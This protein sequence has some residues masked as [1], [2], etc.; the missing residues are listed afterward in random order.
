[1]QRNNS[2]KRL[3]RKA[4]RTRCVLEFLAGGIWA[5]FMILPLVLPVPEVNA[6]ESVP[7]APLMTCAVEAEMENEPVLYDVPLDDELQLFIIQE[8]EEHHIEPEI[9]LAMIE[10]ESQFTADIVGDNGN[11]FGYLQIQPRWHYQRMLDL[12]CTNLLDPQQNVTVGIDLLSDLVDRYEGNIAK[13]LTA[14]N[15]GS[16]KGTVSEYAKAVLEK[17]GEIDVLHG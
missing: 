5:S 16:F 10:R 6:L 17:A 7:A 3:K 14:Y 15:Q 9:I 8:C 12:D 13:A 2:Y 11:S 1:M 4:K